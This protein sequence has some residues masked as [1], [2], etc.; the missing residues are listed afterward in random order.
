[1]PHEF[2]PDTAPM[3]SRVNEQCLHMPPV[4]QHE[5]E[6]TIDLI[7]RQPQGSLWQ[8]V[9]NL[10]LDRDAIFVRKEI[11]C[12]IDSRTP[13]SDNASAL[14][15]ARPPDRKHGPMMLELAWRP[16]GGVFGPTAIGSR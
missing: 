8:E 11:V 14:I 10:A 1:M 15:Y 9:L 7:N 2:S 4:H 12:C 16:Q 5:G 6:R 3:K 13:D